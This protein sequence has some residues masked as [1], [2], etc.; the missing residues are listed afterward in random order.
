LVSPEKRFVKS[1]W[2]LNSAFH[3][4]VDREAQ[5]W[6]ILVASMVSI[7]DSSGLVGVE[8]IRRVSL[9][10]RVNKSKEAEMLEDSSERANSAMLGERCER[11]RSNWNWVV[12]D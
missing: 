7:R 3:F 9:V 8:A 11:Y 10:R 6:L 12:Q 4:L 2:P 5:V 1:H